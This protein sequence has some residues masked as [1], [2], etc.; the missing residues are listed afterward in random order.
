MYGVCVSYPKVR[1]AAVFNDNSSSARNG[2]VDGAA[3]DDVGGKTSEA[4]TVAETPSMVPVAAPGKAGGFETAPAKKSQS[5][6]RGRGGSSARGGRRGR[7][8]GGRKGGSGEVADV[9]V[10]RWHRVRCKV[11]P[12]LICRVSDGMLTELWFVTLSLWMPLRCGGAT[13]C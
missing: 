6:P 12:H 3:N 1:P 5:P 2:T 8:T 9:Q 11:T 13:A 10:R 4:P 7:G